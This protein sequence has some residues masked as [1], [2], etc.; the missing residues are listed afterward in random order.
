MSGHRGSRRLMLV[1]GLIAVL[2]ALGCSGTTGPTG[3]ELVGSWG[4]SE[5]ELVALLAGAELRY[6]CSRVIIDEALVLDEANNFAASG[7]LDGPGLT[8]GELPVL[9][10]TGSSAGDQLTIAVASL[11]T[12]KQ[13]SARLATYVLEAGVTRPPQDQPVCP[14]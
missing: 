10:V 8:L 5:A 4:S 11:A 9:R 3:R 14:L 12:P 2:G 7:R 6:G 13:R 1:S